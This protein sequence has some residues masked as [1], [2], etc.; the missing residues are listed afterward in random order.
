MVS[1]TMAAPPLS[2]P[3]SAKTKRHNAKVVGFQPQA[4][5]LVFDAAQEPTWYSQSDYLVFG[6]DVKATVRVLRRGQVA[7]C[8]RGLEKYQSMQYHDEKKRREQTH[9]RTIL[10]EQERQKLDGQ[11]NPKILRMLSTVNSHWATQNAL[12]VAQRDAEEAVRVDD[13]EESNPEFASEESD[14]SDSPPLRL[15]SPLDLAGTTTS[16]ATSTTC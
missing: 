10:L 14:G 5:L 16:A 8:A 7:Q 15:P 2:P 12:Q 4:K 13:E 6:K 1:T 11:T 9:Y 3:R